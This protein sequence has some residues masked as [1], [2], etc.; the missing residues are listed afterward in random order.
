MIESSRQSVGVMIGGNDQALGDMRIIISL[1]KLQPLSQGVLR[2]SLL[3]LNGVRELIPGY[4]TGDV[5]GRGGSCGEIYGY[6]GVARF[7][8]NKKVQ[9]ADQFHG[10]RENPLELDMRDD[11]HWRLAASSGS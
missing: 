11:T 7:S 8:G 10:G 5:D 9:G 6:G 4:C 1:I 2:A 3:K